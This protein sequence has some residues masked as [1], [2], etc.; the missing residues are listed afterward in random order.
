MPHHQ[1][2]GQNLNTKIAK[3]FKKCGNA[4]LSENNSNKSK[5]HPQIN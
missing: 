4:E 2:T 1:D 5:L 3:F